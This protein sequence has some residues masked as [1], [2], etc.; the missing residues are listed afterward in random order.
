[1]GL[2]NTFEKT[3]KTNQALP[4]WI[5]V[6]RRPVRR[7]SQRSRTK[8]DTVTVGGLLNKL[9]HGVRCY[10]VSVLMNCHF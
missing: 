9:F 5:D 2:I 3:L 4:A 10:W 6:H 8:I 1:M 7:R